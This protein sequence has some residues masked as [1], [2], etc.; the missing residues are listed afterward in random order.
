MLKR[1]PLPTQSKRLLGINDP[2]RPS[3]MLV[4][5]SFAKGL[6]VREIS[7]ILGVTTQAVYL[8]KKALERRDDI[9]RLMYLPLFAALIEDNTE[10]K[11]K[12]RTSGKPPVSPSFEI[13]EADGGWLTSEGIAVAGGLNPVS[14]NRSLYRWL[15][16]GF[17]ESRSVGLSKARS[18][19]TT[20]NE[21]RTEWRT[22]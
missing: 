11:G 3:R 7:Q 14:V 21:E 9:N 18:G 4:E 13:L 15:K 22:L 16:T 10:S 20:K 12:G 5:K 1:Y 17:V 19:R 2:R 6:S 8:H